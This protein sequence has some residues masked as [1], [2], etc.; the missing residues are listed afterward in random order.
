MVSFHSENGPEARAIE[1]AFRQHYPALC[2][3]AAR[4]VRSHPDGE[5]LVQ[6]VFLHLWEGRRRLRPIRNLRAYLYSA[7]RNRAL[8]RLKHLRVEQRFGTV[9]F[10]PVPTCRDPEE[11]VGYA[12]LA[13]AT[14][15]AVAG[16]PERCR[17]AFRLSRGEGRSYA[18][19]AEA[20]QVSVK[21][22]ET[23]IRRATHALRERLGPYLS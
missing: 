10:V 22:V 11:E 23:Q 5:D 13:T 16:L 19:T 9:E 21:T 20:M 6:D 8:D 2:R 1:N 17:E 3:F 18:E 15:R 4:H 7:V 12:E 14:E